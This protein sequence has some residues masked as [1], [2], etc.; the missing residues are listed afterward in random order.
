MGTGAHKSSEGE[1]PQL[2]VLV[3]VLVMDVGEHSGGDRGGGF[4][5]EEEGRENSEMERRFV[6]LALVL[7]E[8]SEHLELAYAYSRWHTL[9]HFNMII[10]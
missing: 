3:V 9:L 5:E 8:F 1:C 7:V 6:P 2:V 4:G 10:P